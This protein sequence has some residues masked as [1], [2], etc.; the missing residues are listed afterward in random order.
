MQNS[1]QTLWDCVDEGQARPTARGDCLEFEG[2]AAAAAGLRLAL[3]AQVF[4]RAGEGWIY[5]GGTSRAWSLGA[6][7]ALGN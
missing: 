6:A 2:S 5:L 4:G 1:K 7:W 3:A